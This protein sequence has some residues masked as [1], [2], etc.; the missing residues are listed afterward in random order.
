MKKFLYPW[1]YLLS[2]FGSLHAAEVDTVLIYSVSMDKNIPAVVVKPDVYS[3]DQKDFPVVFLL[4]GYS[5]NYLN[6][7]QKTDLGALSDQY[8]LLLVC[9]DGGYNS[10]YLDSPLDASSQYETHIIGEVIPFIDSTYRTITDRKGRAI[11]GLSMGGQGALYLAAR[12]PDIFVAASSM[13]GGVDLTYSTV[14]WEIAQKLGSYEEY[15]QR[16]RKHSAVNMVD[17]FKDHSLALFIDCGVE[18]I[19]IQVNRQLHRRLLERNIPHVY[20]E[21]PGGHSW[22]Y[23]VNAL[24]YHLLFFKQVFINQGE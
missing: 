4:H 8:E 18:D 3:I 10:W 9:P 16:W 12:H 6:W 1:V 5:G 20:I 24:P 23:W 13:S 19:F 15:P 22:E 7:S 21:R 17:L 11:T 2:V 14:K